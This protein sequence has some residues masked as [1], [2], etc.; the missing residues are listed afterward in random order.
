MLREIAE[1]AVPNRQDIKG[2]VRFNLM[3]SEKLVWVMQGVDYIE[4]IVRRERPG[5]SHGL[6]TR[7]ARGIYY[8]PSTFRSRV[9]EKDETVHQGTGLLGFTTKHIYFSDRRRSSGCATIRLWTSNPT[10]TAS[11][12]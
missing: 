6:S 10:A 12:S 7:V 1:G 2:T 11:S 4:T 5:S 8:L 9:I 3:K